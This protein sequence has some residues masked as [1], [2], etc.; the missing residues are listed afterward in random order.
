MIF[1]TFLSR[2]FLFTASNKNHT[3]EFNIS[4]QQEFDWKSR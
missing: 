4:T 1:V 2:D 3:T